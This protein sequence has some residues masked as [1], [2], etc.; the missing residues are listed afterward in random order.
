MHVVQIMQGVHNRVPS[1]PAGTSVEFFPIISAE[2]LP[3]DRHFPASKRLTAIVPPSRGLMALILTRI[4]RIARPLR[5]T[6]ENAGSA[7]N[8]AHSTVLI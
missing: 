7:H 2:A 3:L 4:A 8:S 6:E 5:R 1:G